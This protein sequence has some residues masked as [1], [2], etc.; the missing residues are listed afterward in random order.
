MPSGKTNTF[1]QKL[2]AHSRTISSISCRF[3]QY[4]KMAVLEGTAVSHGLFYFK[5]PSSVRWEY[6][7]PL[8]TVLVLRGDT[9]HIKEGDTVSVYDMGGNAA[10]RETGR[11]ITGIVDGSAVGN[12]RIFLTSF[13]ESPAQYLVMLA[14][15][16]RKV[17]KYL[18][19][20]KLYLEKSDL[21]AARIIIIE[22]NGDETEYRFTEKCFNEEI[23]DALFVLE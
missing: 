4:K 21:S 12:S 16:E 8:Q 13:F 20:I 14:P 6:T 11:W 1:I 2:E 18:D 15:R 22:R 10:L 5:S 19:V 3:T 17:E 7:R 23:P 9:A